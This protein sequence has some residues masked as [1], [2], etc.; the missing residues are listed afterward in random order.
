MTGKHK[1]L[2]LSLGFLSFILLIMPVSMAAEQGN[3][4]SDETLRIVNF[5]LQDT[6]VPRDSYVSTS[7][8]VQNHGINTKDAN[9]S[10]DITSD[11]PDAD[12]SA[13]RYKP[14][15]QVD[16]TL[17]KITY[18]IEDLKPSEQRVISFK[19]LFEETGDYTVRAVS[20]NNQGSSVAE[21]DISVRGVGA[22]VDDRSIINRFKKS[23][24]TSTPTSFNDKD[25]FAAEDGED[26]TI[27]PSTDR[28][29]NIYS[30]Q[31]LLDT[32]ANTYSTLTTTPDG[33]KINVGFY[34]DSIGD[35]EHYVLRFT[36]NTTQI[37]SGDDGDINAEINIVDS[38]GID[39][40]KDTTYKF[41]TTTEITTR[42]YQL[43]PE[44]T[45]YIKK[46]NELFVTINSK[47]VV[48]D[49]TNNNRGQIKLGRI[50]VEEYEE[51]F[52]L[53]S[54]SLEATVSADGNG[55]NNFADNLI[56]VNKNKSFKLKAQIT[57]TGLNTVTR[58]ITLTEKTESSPAGFVAESTDKITIS[59]GMTKDIT[60]SLSRREGGIHNFSVLDSH[61]EVRVEEPSVEI[62]PTPIVEKTPEIPIESKDTVRIDASDSNDI[63]GDN[64]KLQYNW[65]TDNDGSFD[66]ASGEVFEK[67][68]DA[69]GTYE[70]RLNVTDEEGVSSEYVSEFKVYKEPKADSH[71]RYYAVHKNGEGFIPGPRS[72]LGE[73]HN[74]NADVTS[75]NS[76]E[77]CG[78][79]LVYDGN[80]VEETSKGMNMLVLDYK[81]ERVFYD[82]YS[83]NQMNR[84]SND[85]T[86][87]NDKTGYIILLATGGNVDKSE[88][89]S[90]GLI[91]EFKQLGGINGYVDTVEDDSAWIFMS[92]VGDGGLVEKY[93]SDGSISTN[94][95]ITPIDITGGK[96][97][98]P[99]GATVV[100][101]S[102]PSFVPQG[103][104]EY[105][106][107]IDNAEDYELI[108]QKQIST[109]S[110]NYS[111]DS[112]KKS[113]EL[114]VDDTSTGLSDTGEFTITAGNEAP[115][116]DV[117]S[118]SSINSSEKITLD[119]TE[120]YDGDG[121]IESYSWNIEGYNGQISSI[122]KQSV[123][124]IESGTR[125][126]SLTVTDDNG[127]TH[128]D[129]TSVKVN[130]IPP[131]QEVTKGRIGVSYGY[132][133]DGRFVDQMFTKSLENNVSS[134]SKNGFEINPGSAEE[135]D[136][137]FVGPIP[138]G[139]NRQVSYNTLG[140]SQ[141]IDLRL[142]SDSEQEE[143]TLIDPGAEVSIPDN[144]PR[145]IR[146]SSTIESGSATV[147]QLR[148]LAKDS[149][150]KS[151]PHVY[152]DASQSSDINGQ[153]ESYEWDLDNDG[154]TEQTGPV[155]SYEYTTTGTKTITLTTTDNDGASSRKEYTLEVNDLSP[156]SVITTDIENNIAQIANTVEMSAEQSSDVS[157]NID[158]Y[159]WYVN[160]EHKS[161]KSISTTFDS[162]GEYKVRLSVQ[163]KNGLSST[164]TEVIKVTNKPPEASLDIKESI[165]VGSQLTADASESSDPEG[166]ELDYKWDVPDSIKLEGN[167]NNVELTVN[168]KESFEVS[169]TVTDIGGKT[170]TVTK[171]VDVTNTPPEADFLTNAVQQKSIG[172]PIIL[173]GIKSSDPDGHDITYKWQID[174]E[175]MGSD[176]KIRFTPDTF[177]TDIK[178][179]VEDE[180]GASDSKT[181]TIEFENR[182]PSARFEIEPLNGGLIVGSTVRYD[183]TASLD[184]E[185]HDLNYEWDIDSD[186]QTEKEGKVVTHTPQSLDEEVTLTVT[187]EYGAED[188][189]TKQYQLKNNKPTAKFYSESAPKL[190][191]QVTYNAKN[192]FDPDGHELTYKWDFD[193][194][195]DTERTGET[196][197]YQFESSKNGVA[198][199]TVVDE[200]GKT[201]SITQQYRLI[202]FDPTITT[203][204]NQKARKGPTQSE[205]R[206]RYNHEALQDITVKSG[207]QII[208][209]PVSGIYEITAYGAAGRNKNPNTAGEGAVV[210]GTFELQQGDKLKILV[211]QQSPYDDS[212]NWYG[213]SGGT[214]VT[215]GSEKPLLVAGGGAGIEGLDASSGPKSKMRG[216]LS[217]DGASGQYG[218]AGSDGNGG[219]GSCNY[220]GSY[221]GSAGAGFITNGD[222]SCDTRFGNPEEAKSFK[223]GGIGGYFPDGDGD[224]NN[225]GFGGGG[226]GGWAGTGGGGG[227]S[228]GGAGTTGG[229]HGYGGG[230]GSF[231][232]DRASDP[233]T[234]NGNW[235]PHA[236]P[237]DIHTGG[238]S[239]LNKWSTGAG[240]VTIEPR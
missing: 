230:G 178:L 3:L 240:K 140:N 36:H 107:D 105:K 17:N 83:N 162:S 137:V 219:D 204:G 155:T 51:P 35:S 31:S 176:K 37:N 224:T 19:V 45:E 39:I 43:S 212:R 87:Y 209:V 208:E 13:V 197:K 109:I 183:A 90:N 180:Y 92:R 210:S 69:S 86:E 12:I 131:S 138:D 75:C 77:D 1:I 104:A 143:S 121:I 191:K 118:Y 85:I 7:I 30:Y 177:E 148:T 108:E 174:G 229:G 9:L 172:L 74:I 22:S 133:Q 226:S 120:S 116:A 23:V 146:L 100:H 14:K 82:S 159:N 34:F 113:F 127:N 125:E 72:E 189:E 56:Q 227:Y 68:Y 196:V 213:G 166:E 130:N 126:I 32:N 145:Q 71:S 237:H 112:D 46:N 54:S 216:Q 61:V 15:S 38:R 152:F 179:T 95:Q 223:N 55:N 233:A 101:S 8:I 123:T 147:T 232:H 49:N 236:V 41:S 27:P 167:G 154:I 78:I 142:I 199:L 91:G 5:E 114:R 20:T 134:E 222:E 79:S 192:S 211:G 80:S 205:C 158:E 88:L 184:F 50:S 150:D 96:E 190:G 238:V 94:Q 135:S 217:T 65:D 2:L 6:A 81:G 182:K 218:D 66:D 201:D 33:Q 106:W 132:E 129:T 73:S 93:S 40:D 234:S 149:S 187:D 141:Q 202:E 164:I 64:S 98:V 193:E 42:R 136:S 60:F 156:T 115:V 157:N 239:S 117:G 47:G 139:K 28:K 206:D 151:Y 153:I 214:F 235:E 29:G 58:Q 62:P 25:G 185:N 220:F 67:T 70:V 171:V 225:G 52:A 103:P 195:G 26:D 128:T 119:A 221:T 89:A 200:Y 207:I 110:R 59:P 170:D 124:L 122:D 97:T 16:D 53:P 24:Q 175:S 48:S 194:D 173:N 84:L 63:D 4:K 215:T 99:R 186:G 10:L 76:E 198:K 203:C 11:S 165:T 57:N 161:G 111:W 231:I 181:T 160:G 163:D 144:S 21:R 102:K 188:V 44:E 18:K 169:V 168:K 228:G